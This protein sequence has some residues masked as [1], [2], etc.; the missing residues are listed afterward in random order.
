MSIRISTE[1]V[2]DVAVLQCLG[3]VADPDEL[4][5]LKAA[6]TSLSQYRVVVLDLTEVKMV[7]ARG[8]GM[9]VFLH[10]WAYAKGIQ[11]RFVNPSNVVR[12]MLEV[13]GLI[14]VLHISS[15]DDLVEMYCNS[16]SV[17]ENADR[18][19]A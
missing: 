19:A 6:V 12:R 14:S 2:D 13:T 17:I 3:R 1:Q 5:R 10:N 15:I 16:H 8:L 11:L 18:A 9:L 7:D 4:S